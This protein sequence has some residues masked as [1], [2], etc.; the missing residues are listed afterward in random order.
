MR[1]FALKELQRDSMPCFETG[2]FSKGSAGLLGDVMKTS[3]IEL[4]PH[5]IPLVEYKQSIDNYLVDLSGIGN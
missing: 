1:I 3:L 4:R 2:F 5:M